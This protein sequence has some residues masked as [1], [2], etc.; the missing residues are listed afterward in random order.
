MGHIRNNAEKCLAAEAAVAERLR[1]ILPPPLPG[2]LGLALARITTLA[3]NPAS[4]LQSDSDMLTD[5]T[6]IVKCLAFVAMLVFLL[7]R[8]KRDPSKNTTVSTKAGYGF[9]AVECVLMTATWLIHAL[10]G[11]D[12]GV[13]RGLSTVGSIVGSAGLFY[14]LVAARGLG[15]SKAIAHVALARLISEVLSLTMDLLPSCEYIFGLL[16]LLGQALCI[17]RMAAHPL[18]GAASLSADAD[19][20]PSSAQ[21]LRYFSGFEGEFKDRK[22]LIT[23]VLSCIMLSAAVGLLRGFPDGSSIFFTV[24]TLVASSILT[25][26][27][28]LLALR[29]ATRKPPVV[30]VAGCWVIIMLLACL[31]LLAFAAWP[32]DRSIGA[33]FATVFNEILHCCRW[34]ISIALMGLGWRNPYYYA[35]TTYLVFMLPRAITRTVIVAFGPAAASHAELIS[36]LVTLILILSCVLITLR[37]AAITMRHHAADTPTTTESIVEKILGIDEGASL[38]EMRAETMR[39]NAEAIGQT[40]QLSAREVEVLALF[41]SGHTQKRVAEEL[42]ISQSTAHAHIRHIY[43]KTGFHSRQEI[44]DYMQDKIS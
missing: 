39:R 3:L 43:T 19:S 9:V 41:A 28:Y 11:T 5:W 31:A 17:R 37:I 21:T 8:S 30:V 18:T 16:A 32:E 33:V 22:F 24:P 40:F 20:E 35:V 4:G 6:S 27:I 38:A 42:F 2:I 12:A 13:Y 15:P 23:C 36:A 14:W 26:L 1:D 10:E 44:L 34:Y 7:A 29:F 25:A